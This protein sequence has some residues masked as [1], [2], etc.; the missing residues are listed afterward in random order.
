MA[1]F[2]QHATFPIRVTKGDTRPEF[3]LKTR[4]LIEGLV[5]ICS[6][7]RFFSSP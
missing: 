3:D 2:M 5:D 7:Y 6:R 4:P 1:H